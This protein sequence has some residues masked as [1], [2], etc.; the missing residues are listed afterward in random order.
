M[1]CPKKKALKRK[2]VCYQIEQIDSPIG[3]VHRVRYYSTKTGRFLAFL[4][5]ESCHK[6]RRPSEAL[7]R[8]KRKDAVDNGAWCAGRAPTW[9]VTK[10]AKAFARE[11]ER[12]S[13]KRPG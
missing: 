3:K 7:V 6:T 5:N 11:L 10:A 12:S 9:P 2:G 4:K 13:R 1:A 8:L